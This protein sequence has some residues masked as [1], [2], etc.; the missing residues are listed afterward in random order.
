MC[1]RIESRT[2]AHIHKYRLAQKRFRR[3]KEVMRKLSKKMALG[4][5]LTIT[6]TALSPATAAD[7]ASKPAWKK[8]TTSTTV[9][10]KVTFQVKNVPAGGKVT[11][12]SSKVKVAKITK[13]T[14]VKA[15]VKALK[16]GK[17]VILAV[18]KN[19]KG[20]VVKTLKKT[21]TVKATTVPTAT[22]KVTV[23]PNMPTV[24]PEVTPT[25]APTKT[26]VTS[27]N[28]KNW[29]LVITPKE[30]VITADGGDNTV[31]TFQIINTLTQTVDITANDITLDV[32]AY[33]GQ[34]SN[35]SVVIKNGTATL[36]LN[37]V[38]SA[39][40]LEAKVTANISS[41]TN[42]ATD[43]I[44][45]VAGETTVKFAP[46]ITTEDKEPKLV[47][48]ES[49]QADRVTLFFDREVTVEDFVIKNEATGT[50]KV[51]EQD[52]Y[53]KQVFINNDV[54]KVQFSISQDDVAGKTVKYPI[55]GLKQVEDNKKALELLIHESKALDD[56]N[57]V[58]VVYKNKPCGINTEK[59]FHLTDAK[60]PYL[61][62]VK[63]I[64]MKTVELKFSEAI[65]EMKNVSG[66][67]FTISTDKSLAVGKPVY[68]SFDPATGIDK[69]AVVLVPL[70]LDS[71]GKQEYFTSE[72][73]KVA[74]ANVVDYAGLSDLGKNITANADPKEEKITL[75]TTRP[76]IESVVVESPEQYRII[77]NAPVIF[78]DSTSTKVTESAKRTEYFTK[79][80]QVKVGN[81]YVSVFDAYY[82]L[83][84]DLALG[85][86]KV[87]PVLDKELKTFLK[88][89]KVSDREYVVE[90]TQDWTKFYS[91]NTTLRDYY[92][93]QY[94]FL[95]AA[96][97]VINDNNGL[98]NPE[99]LIADLSYE[100][101]PLKQKDTS[102]P[103]NPTILRTDDD[104]YFVAEFNEPLQ[105]TNSDGK[106]YVTLKD[107]Q[108]AQPANVVFVGTDKNGDNKTVKGKVMQYYD[109]AKKTDTKIK[110]EAIHVENNKSY[111]LQDF[112][113]QGYEN[114]TMSLD[115]ISDD[116]GNPTQTVTA[117][118]TIKP[119]A[120]LFAIQ[121]INAFTAETAA[122]ANYDYIDVTFSEGVSPSSA[123]LAIS[124]WKLDGLALPVG[125][126]VDII[127]TSGTPKM[128]Y[129]AIRFIIPKDKNAIKKNKSHILNVDKGITS[130]KGIALTGAFENKFV[131][132]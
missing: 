118:F 55:V 14:T 115:G 110:I 47:K 16:K 69:R 123:V 114:W 122:D 29:A 96:D 11:F 52:G 25:L 20:K 72:Q 31:L 4:L 64:G 39:K 108:V 126:T 43:L 128:G 35:S 51:T 79:A 38:F 130:L 41:Q 95:F 57:E 6:V 104:N 90:L 19:K 93:D 32:A 102:S 17:T 113:N 109:N 71:Q 3:K 88:I 125:A 70:G 7:A 61:T 2:S 111:T 40:E 82:K 77:F 131:A 67:S 23:T 81:K 127:E 58:T 132:K 105:F 100:G 101:S 27:N 99:Q 9:G 12:R 103:Q 21:L 78:S 8:A 124:S 120:G 85:E 30:K 76:T 121:E 13:K 92:D 116:V 33:L 10:K 60:N 83:N 59:S 62:G 80:L 68:G 22:P 74:I 37:S 119:Q 66:A 97:S 65:P 34:L 56:N 15:T 129:Y 94:R 63:A 73:I 89:T 112:A 75:D 46:I 107:G 44:G 28:Y 84:S 18:V 86:N 49:D 87:K 98:E 50:Y 42:N 24:A 53:N 26:P 1:R 117:A 54:S 48:A 91:T 5:A 106:S 36:V 45:K